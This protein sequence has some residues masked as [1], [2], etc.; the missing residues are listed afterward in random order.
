MSLAFDR[1]GSGSPVVLLHAGV[2]D[3]GMWDPQWKSLSGAHTVV[4]PDLPGFGDSAYPSGEVDPAAEV[5]TLLDDLGL[6]SVAVVGASFGGRVAIEMAARWAERVSALVT[7]AAFAPGIPFTDD[8]VAFD[9][10]ES[11]LLEAGDLAGAAAL[12]AATWLGPEAD[13]GARDLVRAAQLRIFEIQA[14]GEAEHPDSGFRW[15]N[16]D[17]GTIS[18]RTM[19]AV[20][21]H[22]LDFFR[23]AAIHLVTAI[24]GARLVELPWAGHLPSLERPAEVTTLLLDFLG[25]D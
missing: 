22:D 18:A 3:R 25:D 15:V 2:C 4:R 12:N 24:P 23:T 13:D 16:P 8:F 5:M 7:L 1:A 11:D 14:A 9:E 20:G 21:G 6:G 10:A 19:V 17:P